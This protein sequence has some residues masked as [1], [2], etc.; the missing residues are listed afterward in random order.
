[1][2]EELKTLIEMNSTFV[3]DMDG[4]ITEAS[5]REDKFGVWC[6]SDNIDKLKRD[7]KYDVYK[8]I[9]VM[10]CTYDFIREIMADDNANVIKVL[11][12]AWNGR[13]VMNKARCLDRIFNCNFSE[14][15]LIAVNNEEDKLAVLKDTDNGEN[16]VYIDDNLSTLIKLEE[17]NIPGLTCLHVSSLTELCSID[18]LNK[19]K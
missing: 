15:N 11:T 18:E 4:T 5:F 10:K 12:L 17:M 16:V 8:N 1:M 6:P 2:R 3:F 9:K 7:I 19:C 13:E 14:D